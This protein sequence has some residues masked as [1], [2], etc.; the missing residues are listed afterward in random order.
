MDF[1]REGIG[2]RAY[3]Q[4]DPLLEYKKE[5][6]QMF[7]ELMDAIEREVITNLFKVKVISEDEMERL[8][9]EE[10]NRI[11]ITSYDRD[12]NNK[13]KV[14]QTKINKDNKPGR[15]EACPCGSGKKYKVC[16]GKQS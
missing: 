1:L 9:E 11:K 10:Q 3:A 12:T 14:S 4:K 2:L 15:N 5:G 13:V 7:Q 8:M 6:Y 16:C